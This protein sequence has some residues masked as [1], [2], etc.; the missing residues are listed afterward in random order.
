MDGGGEYKTAIAQFWSS[1]PERLIP[2]GDLPKS[3]SVTSPPPE[4]AFTPTMLAETCSQSSSDGSLA[5]LVAG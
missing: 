4:T 3:W 2:R 1:L 5:Q